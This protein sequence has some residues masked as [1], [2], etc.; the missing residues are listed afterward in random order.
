MDIEAQREREKRQRKNERGRTQSKKGLRRGP[1]PHTYT[2][3]KTHITGR[4]KKL[5]N[6]PTKG[7]NGRRDG[8]GH[9]GDG[10][11]F[12]SFHPRRRGSRW[13]PQRTP[14]DWVPSKAQLEGGITI[15]HE[16]RGG[17]SRGGAVCPSWLRAAGSMGRLELGRSSGLRLMS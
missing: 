17:L 15:L 2:H 6:A 16:C 3:T 5:F 14:G 13:S 4:R 12:G 7:N 11:V 9:G 10:Q 1:P 8:E